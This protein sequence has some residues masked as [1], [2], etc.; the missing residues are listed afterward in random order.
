M[1]RTDARISEF[2]VS[3]LKK[4]LGCTTTPWLK[5]LSQLK[6]RTHD[7]Y[8][9]PPRRFC[10]NRPWARGLHPRVR[11][12]APAAK[13]KIP[14]TI[15]PESPGGSGALVGFINPG[16]LRDR[17]PRQGSTQ[18]YEATGRKGGPVTDR[19]VWPKRSSARL[20]AA[21]AHLSDRSVRFDSSRHRTASPIGRPSPKHYFRL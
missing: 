18:E 12:R 21:S 14:R 13:I 10:P 4:Y 15:L 3:K 11:S 9:T 1:A 17:L 8:R 5:T 16:S 19:K 20:S 7:R 2:F 6:T